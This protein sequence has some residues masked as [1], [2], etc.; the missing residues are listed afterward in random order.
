MKNIKDYLYLYLGCEVM[1]EPYEP[2]SYKDVIEAIVVGE[3]VNFKKA[4]DYYFD[5][6]NEFNIKLILRPLY[7]MTAKERLQWFREYRTIPKVNEYYN[8]EEL[9]WLLKQGFDLFN[10]IPEGLAID[11][12]KLKSEQNPER[13]VATGLNQGINVDKQIKQNPF[14][15]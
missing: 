1:I 10:L 3:S 4:G 5:D 11:K 15:G 12:T 14:G 6:A 9:R 7:D 13:S 2:H 8:P